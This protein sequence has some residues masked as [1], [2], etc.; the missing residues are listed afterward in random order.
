MVARSPRP[1]E[2]VASGVSMSRI[3]LVE[4]SSYTWA[5]TARICS[6]LG[7]RRNLPALGYHCPAVNFQGPGD[8]TRSLVRCVARHRVC[9]Y[10]PR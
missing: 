10:L 7:E 4:R 1:L 9:T 5:A 6:C 3:R 2:F 8:W